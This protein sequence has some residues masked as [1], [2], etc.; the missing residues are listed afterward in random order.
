MARIAEIPHGGRQVRGSNEYAIDAGD[1]RDLL[2]LSKRFSG[3]YLHQ[4]ADL[5]RSG[6]QIIAG[7]SEIAGA[8]RSRHAPPS[9]G[10]IAT[11]LYGATCFFRTLYEGQQ[12]RL[13]PNIQY[14]LDE[15]GIVPRGPHYRSSRPV[16]RRLQQRQQAGDF[17]R[18]VF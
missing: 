6:F 18:R 8:R 16:I 7:P 11:T 13:R 2:E 5:L 15:Y 3:L 17:Y 1:T 4:N 14:A 9:I 10:R 12:N